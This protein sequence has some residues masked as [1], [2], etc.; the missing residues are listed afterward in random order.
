MDC[1]G[2][3]PAGCG[4]APE[5]ELAGRE[6]ILL[7]VPAG[8]AFSGRCNCRL[9]ACFECRRTQF[10]RM[11]THLLSLPIICMNPCVMLIGDPQIQSY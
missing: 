6:R 1:T 5:K 9:P 7:T 3:V 10:F 8:A 2:G 4:G 11:H